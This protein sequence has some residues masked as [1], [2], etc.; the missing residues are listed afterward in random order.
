MHGLWYTPFRK[1]I[2]FMEI[3]ERLRLI[4]KLTPSLPGS[5]DTLSDARRLLVADGKPDDIEAIAALSTQLMRECPDLYP[6][7][8]YIDDGPVLTSMPDGLGSF[9]TFCI[10][11]EFSDPI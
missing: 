5:L 10:K 6:S 9:Y 8:L 4:G 1:E 2:E 11:P 7:K 3:R